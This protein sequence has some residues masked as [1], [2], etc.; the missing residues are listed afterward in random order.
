MKLRATPLALLGATAL[1]VTL[2]ANVAFACGSHAAKS[3]SAA[4][5][6][7]G[8][9]CPMSAC[10]ASAAI[11][12]P[13]SAPL[14]VAELPGLPSLIAQPVEPAGL[15]LLAFIDPET[16]LVGGPIGAL[17]AELT[18]P[19]VPLPV[20]TPVPLANGGVMIDLQGAMQDYVILTL[21]A[22]GNRSFRCASDLLPAAKSKQ[23]ATTSTPSSP[24]VR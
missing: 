24:S 3:A 21:D 10:A 17:P 7:C 19:G 12:K 9:S 23:P 16:G 5:A 15:G 22:R 2:A 6:K 14:V 4:N 13:A 1:A 11:V 18:R 20:F 8:H